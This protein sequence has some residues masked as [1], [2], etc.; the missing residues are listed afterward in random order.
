MQAALTAVK[1]ARD[2]AREVEQRLGRT[3]L[4]RMALTMGEVVTGLGNVGQALL[5]EKERLSTASGMVTG[6]P[7]GASAQEVLAV[8]EPAG[9]QL[10]D[11]PGRLHDLTGPVEDLR[12]AVAATLKGAQ[13]GP[14]LGKLEHV[15]KCLS[16]VADVVTVAGQRTGDLITDTRGAGGYA[17]TSTSSPMRAIPGTSSVT[18]AGQEDRIHPGVPPYD[19]GKVRGVLRLDDAET[20]LV[21]GEDGPG[22]WLVNNLP[23][24]PGSGLTRAWTHVEGHAAGI[25]RER[26]V[27]RAELFINKAPCATGAAKCRFV[28]NKLIPAGS[29]LDVRFPN[30]QGGATTWRF[31]GGEKGWKEL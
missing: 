20:S 30:E 5:A 19:G 17:A 24:G 10:A 15:K 22:R 26:E 2:H 27:K 18:R 16:G 11:V 9:R 31:T 1:Q 8:L 28:L 12:A 23:G 29:V 3:G 21:S 7:T 13:P 6:L 14:L 25:M 4:P